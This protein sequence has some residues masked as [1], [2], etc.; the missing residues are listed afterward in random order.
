MRLEREAAEAEIEDTK[1]PLK[2]AKNALVYGAGGAAATTLVLG[3]LARAIPFLSKFLPTG[4]AVKGLSKVAPGF[5]KMFEKGEE[6]GLDAEE[7]VELL[8]EKMEPF[9]EKL[10]PKQKAQSEAL[11]KYRDYQ[12]KKGNLEQQTERFQNYYGQPQEEEGGNVSSGQQAIL[13]AIKRA[14]G[15]M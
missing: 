8:R 14:Q 15:L 3:R 11:K 4:L 9:A 5:K 6:A 7:G 2:A 1:R 12:K 13:D 10:H